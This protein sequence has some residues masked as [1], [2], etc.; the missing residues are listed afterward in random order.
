[1][2]SNITINISN[3]KKSEIQS[4]AQSCTHDECEYKCK[5]NMATVNMCK[6]SAESEREGVTGDGERVCEMGG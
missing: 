6:Q 2:K 4:K 5:T 3:E 1:M